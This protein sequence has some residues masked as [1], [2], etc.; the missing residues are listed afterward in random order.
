[1]QFLDETDARP[2]MLSALADDLGTGTFHSA[3]KRDP[4]LFGPLNKCDPTAKDRE[5][6]VNLLALSNERC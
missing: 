2:S 1:M 3:S 4:T 5:M 6:F